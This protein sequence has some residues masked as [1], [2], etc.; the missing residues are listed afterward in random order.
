MFQLNKKT[1]IEKNTKQVWTFSKIVC[2]N[3]NSFLNVLRKT[4]WDE[5][6]QVL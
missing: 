4:N 5:T 2:T 3:N 1:S 6:A